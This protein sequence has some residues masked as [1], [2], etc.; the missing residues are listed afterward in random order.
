MNR[1]R[2]LAPL[3]LA[4][5]AGLL[6]TWSCTV[7]S[8]RFIFDDDEFDKKNSGGTTGTGGK[9][10]LGGEGGETASG[11]LSALGGQGGDASTGGSGVTCPTSE[12]ECNGKQLEI[13]TGSAWLPV[14]GPCQFV[15]KSDQCTGVCEPGASE[16]VNELERRF[17]DD[18]GQWQVENCPNACI[19]TT[20][21]GECQP[22]SF[23]CGTPDAGGTPIEVCNSG[24]WAGTTTIC[25]SGCE[26]GVCTGECS[27]GDTQ[28]GQTTEGQPAVVTCPQNGDWKD[29]TVTPCTDQACYQGACTG[30][31]LPGNKTCN[32]Q[33]RR[34]C[35]TT[36]AWEDQ[37]CDYVCTPNGCIGECVPGAESCDGTT[38]LKCS[39]KGT[40]E[41]AEK[42]ADRG[43]ICVHLSET[44]KACGECNPD[45]DRTYCSF[46]QARICNEKAE[47]QVEEDCG[48]SEQ[49]CT[50]GKCFDPKLCPGASL[51]GCF[52]KETGWTCPL[53]GKPA[54][55]CDCDCTSGTSC[56]RGLCVSF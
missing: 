41:A 3:A 14:G 16:C 27:E 48:R 31:C 15:C 6:G 30:E 4:L 50:S 47:W 7:D 10:S 2:F 28:C 40:W 17:C 53:K 51:A 1:A 44:D 20:C 38:L 43:L 52:D 42:C 56:G 49:L 35:S 24:N 34:V 45:P 33:T 37:T 55:K 12:L 32:G 36:G 54:Q 39:E 29:A 22:G 8:S 11:G 25:E 46:N 18:D 5:S 19:G 13:C 9:D 26:D 23:Q 21:G